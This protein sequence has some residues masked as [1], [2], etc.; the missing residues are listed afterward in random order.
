MSDPFENHIVGFPMRQLIFLCL[1]QEHA[2]V[3]KEIAA[4]REKKKLTMSQVKPGGEGVTGPGTTGSET[5][6]SVGVA[7]S[8][9]EQQAATKSDVKSD[10]CLLQVM[11]EQV[12][13][14]LQSGKIHLT[15]ESS[16]GNF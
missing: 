11:S 8:S 1:F 14:E 2:R 4:D 6:A 5:G 15:L 16:Q 10:T 12:M 7:T 13:S 9:K 3:L